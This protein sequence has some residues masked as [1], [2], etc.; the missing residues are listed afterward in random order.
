MPGDLTVPIVTAI[1]DRRLLSAD[2]ATACRRLVEWSSQ[3]A[4]AGVDLLQIRE[5]GLPD[6]VHV[7]LVRD[8]LAAA[9]DSA[10]RVMVNDRADIAIAAGAAGVHLPS[11]APAA[12]VIRSIV[13]A[14]FLIGR[15]VHDGDDFSVESQACEYLIFGTVFPSA[16]KAEGHQVAGVEALS[17]ACE[18][19]RV[20]VIAVGGIT[21]SR[22]AACAAAGAAGVAAIRLFF[23]Q[24]PGE[25]RSEDRTAR[26]SDLVARLRAAFVNGRSAGPGPGSEDTSGAS[27][28]D[29]ADDVVDD[30]DG[31]TAAPQVLS[32][33]SVMER[34]K[35]ATKG[36]RE[37]RAQ[38]IRDPN[39]MVAAAVLSSPKLSEPEIEAFARMANVSEDV[40]RII[41]ANRSWMKNYGVAFGLVRNP[42][43]PVSISMQLL[44]RLTARDIKVVA[45]DRNVTEPVRLAA[46]RLMSRS[47][48]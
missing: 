17:R 34:V 36:S 4:A 13:P 35:L 10:M 11:A 19:T 41:S 8:V 23:D 33:L 1:S 31:A 38:L 39:R 20:P 3:L 9:R 47:G 30:A 7:Q 45:I 40:L 24:G 12:A 21:V 29:P 18:A 15:S 16:G 5:R 48:R 6:G 26:L 2:D 22:A 28:L 43:T 37:Q 42:K 14:G 44:H 32:T 25:A 46:R 27:S